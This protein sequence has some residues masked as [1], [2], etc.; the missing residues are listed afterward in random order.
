L[1]V[2]GESAK[3]TRTRSAKEEEEE[4]EE[5][6]EARTKAQTERRIYQESQVVRVIK[7]QGM[8]EMRAV[9]WKET[10]V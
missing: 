5:E 7:G 6:E 10:S 2:L 1:P 9:D 3:E 8:W 4:E